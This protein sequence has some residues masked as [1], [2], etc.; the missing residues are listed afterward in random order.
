MHDRELYGKIL[1]LVKPW[2]VVDVEVDLSAGRVVIEVEHEGSLQCPECGAS[3]PGYDRRRR[4]WRHLDT[5]QLQTV[6]RANVPRVDCAE[7]GVKQI[8]VGWAEANSRFTMMF[9]SLVID[10][11]A[12]ASFSA[13]AHHLRLSWDQVDGI[14]ARAVRRGLA[15][16]TRRYPKRIGVDETSYQKR[17]EYVT[18]VSDIDRSV[19]LEVIDKRTQSSLESYYESLTK[20]QLSSLR[21]VAMDMWPAYIN[22]TMKHLP[23]AASKICFDRFHVMQ[24]LGRGVDDVR[25][26]EHRDLRGD[27]DDRLKRTKYLWLQNPENMSNKRWASFASLRDSS[28]RTARAWAMVH[29]SRFLWSYKTRSGAQRAWSSLLGWM[30]RC[31]LAPMLKAARTVRNHLWGILNAIVQDTT[32]AAAESMNAKIQRIKRMA[33]GYRNRARFRNAIMF[34]LGG[35]NMHPTHT[36]S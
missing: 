28:L 31:R 5:C 6:I 33:C 12:D 30:S 26:A 19:V 32:N 7:H 23:D 3:C 34:H 24:H 13:V 10:W 22:A 8:T 14:M 11:L 1:G 25:K 36:E 15:R 21:A 18:V 27:G 35:L 2:R 20:H 9:E 17:H 16:R 29:A 4:E